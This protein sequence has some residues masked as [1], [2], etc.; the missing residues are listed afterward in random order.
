MGDLHHM[1]CKGL[2]ASTVQLQ[3]KVEVGRGTPSILELVFV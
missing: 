1:Q 2:P 3:K